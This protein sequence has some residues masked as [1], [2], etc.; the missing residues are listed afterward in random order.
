MNKPSYFSRRRLLQIISASSSY[1]ALGSVPNLAYPAESSNSE[2]DWN[3]G[4]LAHLIP[5]AS[6]DQ[7]LIKTSFNSG[8]QQRPYLRLDDR[9]IAGEMTDTQGEFWQFYATDLEPD[10]AY[11]LQLVTENGEELSGSWPLKTFPMPGTETEQ[12]R[13]FAYTCAGGNEDLVGD[14]GTRH[15]LEMASRHKLMQRGL[16][17]NPDVVIA[18][19]DHIYWDQKTLAYR[20][21]S[22]QQ[23]WLE[24]YED[25]GSL[26]PNMP[27]LGTSNEDILKRIADPQIALLYGVSFRSVPVF[28]LTDDHDLFENDEAHEGYISLP[29]E[30]DKL[31]AARATQNLYYPEFLPDATRPAD[32][33]GSSN[34]DRY[35]GF[36]EVYGTFRYG[37]LFEALMYD[38]KRYS[39]LDGAN[40][41]LFNDNAEGWLRSRTET[42][43]TAFLMHIPSTPIAWSAGKW[44]EWYPDA[45]QSDGSLGTDVAK[46]FWVEGWWSQH[47]RVIDMLSS[48]ENRNP[49]IASGDLHA[50]A[51]GEMTQSGDINLQ[52][53]PVSCLC[54]GPI[55]SSGPGFPTIFRGIGAEVPTDLVVEESFKPLEKNGFSIIDVT[56]EKMVIRMYAWIPPEPV[57]DIDSL[58]PFF[59]KEIPHKNYL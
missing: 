2:D 40:G 42:E 54:V 28:M 59:T 53:N 5:V 44:G 20:G 52:D 3:Q 16:S 19:G 13:I 10:H 49:I 48:Q 33:Q 57:E 11:L 25:F 55:G 35:P 29:P 8:L 37:N 41:V 24:M 39:T 7:I 1:I 15:F 50:F 58:E 56:R 30:T 36:S 9:L 21:E 43:D 14:D 12:L 26:D 4:D 18:N 47:Q 32:L 38:T 22:F 45:R 51:Y 46:P 17:F 27:I 34:A 31:A 6:H 23:P